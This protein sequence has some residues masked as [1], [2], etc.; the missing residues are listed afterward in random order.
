MGHGNW[1]FAAQVVGA[2]GR[3]ERVRRGGF[4][5]AEAARSAGCE[6][7][8]A[9]AD[10]PLSAGC[11]V[12]QWLRYWLSV[13]ESR[14]RPTTH[15]AYRDHVRLHL[16]PYLGRV[17][18]VELSR[19]DVTRMF[20]ALGRRRTR[21]GAPISASTLE[22]IRA[23]LRAALNHAVRED[24]IAGNPAQGVRL[25]APVQTHPVVWTARREAAWRRGGERPPVAVWTVEQLAAFLRFA[26]EDPLFVLW[27]LVA[28]RG[29][30]R[31]EVAGLRWVDIDLERRELTVAHQLVHTDEGLV[32][33]EPKSAASRRTLALDPETV[34]L[35]RRHE[36]AQ[37]RGP[38]ERWSPT[39]PVFALG[40]G[41]AVQPSY[42]THRF[43]KLVA[44]SGLPPVRL[45]DLRHGAA[46]LALASGTE[47]K[48]V[49]GT[50]GHAS[51]VLTADTYA[52]VLPQLYHDS[53]KATARL[54]LRAVRATNR[55]I[56]KARDST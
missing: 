42:L 8:T 39:G 32:L 56:G 12:G 23:T 7:L 24:L 17:K 40:S 19:R 16:V 53:A 45:H 35:L 48:V 27:W 50:L 31:G 15:R 29:L 33:C 34:R 13:V 14:L 25:P 5:T 9:Q 49:Q 38:G 10:G 47:L 1:Y 6:L 52:S 2:S 30:R 43:H 11:T 4:A 26:R 44:A 3:R 54:V 36:R 28:L 22:R 21:Y 41:T 55:K 37:R 20:V 18:L 46:T 51:I